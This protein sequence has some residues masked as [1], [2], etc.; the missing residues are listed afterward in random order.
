M[1]T[2]LI[3]K[4]DSVLSNI[5]IPD[6]STFFQLKHFVIGKEPTA[7]GQIWACIRNI[8]EKRDNIDALELQ[9]DDSQD[10]IELLDIRKQRILA[11]IDKITADDPLMLEQELKIQIR[12]IERERMS[13]E[14]NMNNLKLKIKYILEELQYLTSAFEKLTEI[15]GGVKPLD[16]PEVQRNYWNEK[17]TEEINLCLLLKRPLSTEMIHNVLSLDDEMPVK[18]QV[19]QILNQV[20]QQMMAHTQSLLKETAKVEVE[21]G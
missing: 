14:N 3:E 18:K 4:V 8:Q 9:I 6:R 7:H 5:E 17:L 16:D 2:E 20:Q 1:S 13:V 12:K 11:E 15:A 10:N 21:K 19:L